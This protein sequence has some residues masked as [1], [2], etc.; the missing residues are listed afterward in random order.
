ME[1]QL[2][3][4]AMMKSVLI[5]WRSTKIKNKHIMSMLRVICLFLSQLL[6]EEQSWKPKDPSWISN[7]G[8]FWLILSKDQWFDMN[9]QVIILK[10][11]SKLL[12]WAI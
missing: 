8:I 11:Q 7:K 2:L 5:C 3:I 9:V 12:L 1:K 6:Y 10:N 4:F